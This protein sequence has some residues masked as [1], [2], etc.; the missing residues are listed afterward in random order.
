MIDISVWADYLH[1]TRVLLVSCVFAIVSCGD[2]DGVI[3]P[4]AGVDAGFDAGSDAGFDGGFDGGVDGGTD[5]GPADVGVDAFVEPMC[6]EA[7]PCGWRLVPTASAPP[8]ISWAAMA[9]DEVRD[10]IILFGGADTAT[11]ETTYNE[12]WAFDGTNWTQLAVGGPP[13]RWTHG[14]TYDSVREVIVLFGG[15]TTADGA[16]AMNDTWE[17]D[18]AAWTEVTTTNAPSPR[19]VH[20]AM[21]FDPVRERIVLRGG[22]RHPT[23][24]IDAD[25]WEYDGTDWMEITTAE[26][27]SAR[28]GAGMVY[29]E[30][31][32]RMFLFSGGSWGLGPYPEDTW[33][34]DGASWSVLSPTSSP[35]GRQS[36]RLIYDDTR[37]L[38]VLFGGDDGT[39]LDDL[40]EY[41]GTTWTEVTVPGPGA[42]CCFAYAHDRNRRQAVLFGGPDNQTWIYGQ[43]P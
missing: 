5:A 8:S 19:G 42:R 24:P 12:T 28:I 27:P 35:P 21:A 17:W 25:T 30:A 14:M 1:M 4:D 7:N 10:Q 6:S 18:G 38:V 22:G 20:G 3:E 40:W 2:D 41:D 32:G 26:A 15:L 33:S 37:D 23:L 36:G 16:T 39:R 31:R 34:Y 13:T 29:D 11:G 43:E 9:Y